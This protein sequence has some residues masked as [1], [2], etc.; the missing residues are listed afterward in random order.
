[1]AAR[2]IRPAEMITG[3]DRFTAHFDYNR[4]A[5]NLIVRSRQGGDRFQPFGMKE[6]KKIAQFMID[7]KIPHDW[8]DRI[9]IIA[10]ADGI[11]WVAGYRIDE[12][13]KVTK[14]TKKVLRLE[15]RL[16]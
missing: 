2:V 16:V 14:R 8:R 7:A 10:C 15:F 3:D 11:L 5:G 1:M 13:V 9:P 4:V 12:R 6:T